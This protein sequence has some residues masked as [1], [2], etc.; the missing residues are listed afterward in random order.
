MKNINDNLLEYL[1]EKRDAEKYL[2][3]ELG[4][5]EFYISWSGDCSRKIFLMKEYGYEPDI[6][7]YRKFLV[8]NL[9]HIFLRKQVLKL[10]AEVK[11]R[12]TYNNMILRGRVDGRDEK[13]KIIYEF[14]SC[15]K[16]PA[17]PLEHHLGQ[18]MVYLRYFYYKYGDY[19]G[20]LVYLEKNTGMCREFNT[21]YSEKVFKD[22]VFPFKKVIWC[23]E[24]N[25][26]P[27]VL[28]N[29]WRCKY[30]FLSGD[31]CLNRK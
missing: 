13:N 12:Y 28:K 22:A 24:N 4:K 6:K 3:T 26:I 11:I 14:K 19:K 8:G 25:K 9:I 2:Y 5:N 16:L 23:K 31:K 10:G 7:F 15:G 17:L 29:D 30:C 21:F 27:R 1:K 20:K 18:L